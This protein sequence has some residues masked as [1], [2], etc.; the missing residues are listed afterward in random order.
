M[1]IN[2]I[3]AFCLVAVLIGFL[4]VLAIM[5]KHAVELLKKTKTL[6]DKS[7]DA[8]DDVKGRFD[9][10][11]DDALG[12]VGAVAADTSGAVRALTF[13]GAGLTAF[14]LLKVVIGMFTGTGIFSM[15]SAARERKKA[16]KEIKLSKQTIKELNRQSELEKK[17]RRKAAKK[18]KMIIIQVEMVQDQMVAVQEKTEPMEMVQDLEVVVQ[19]QVET[20]QEEMGMDKVLIP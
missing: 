17:A 19:D 15:M 18:T 5:A 7:N 4:V 12:A 20:V 3:I 8:V 16:R 14:G 2:Q 1:T 13:A 11:S 10:L 6:A 9:K